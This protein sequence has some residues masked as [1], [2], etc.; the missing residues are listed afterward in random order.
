MTQ[1][2]T[3][4][5]ASSAAGDNHLAILDPSDTFPRRHIG[6]GPAATQEMLATVGFE[7][8]DALTDAAV[9]A[10]IRLGRELRVGRG[11]GEFEA[12]EALSA[13]AA[14]N[15][16]MRSCIG[17]GYSDTITPPVI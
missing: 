15:V 11:L 14:K 3:G 16:V 17:M 1:V 5:R 9:P 13:I 12:L 8:L 6:P 7:S 2:T 10:A 4:P